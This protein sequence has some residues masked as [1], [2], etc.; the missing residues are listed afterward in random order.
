MFVDD[1]RSFQRSLARSISPQGILTSGAEAFLI[2]HGSSIAPGL[3]VQRVES[4]P[5]EEAPL[6][7]NHEVAAAVPDL[8][9]SELLSQFLY[10]EDHRPPQKGGMKQ[11]GDFSS[12]R[13]PLR[14]VHFAV[15]RASEAG[16]S[17]V[18]QGLRRHSLFY[19]S[20]L[21]NA[22]CTLTGTVAV[23]EDPEL[24][25]R[26]WTDRWRSCVAPREGGFDREEDALCESLD[27][28]LVR[29][30]PEEVELR[31][32]TV[33]EAFAGRRLKLGES[34]WKVAE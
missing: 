19:H 10:T 30:R 14:A 15:P 23:V 31:A 34:G 24:R 21:R 28:V 7:R 1:S 17:F 20:Q 5:P 9:K 32:S 3:S 18:E 8:E 12:E 27:Y 11:Q 4:L 16:T 33:G 2:L 29:F 22:Y 6:R 13:Y 26:Y 25:R